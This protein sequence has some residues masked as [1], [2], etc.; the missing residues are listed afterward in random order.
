M[1]ENRGYS[2]GNNFGAKYLEQKGVEFLFIAN[3]DIEIS[4]SDFDVLLE[5]LKTGEYS[6]VSGVEYDALGN[7]TG[8]VQR[9]D[10]YI[11]DIANCLSIGRRI[12][13]KKQTQDIDF[14]IDIN[15]TEM[16]HGCFFGIRMHDFISIGGLD[17]KVFLYAEERIMSKKFEQCGLKQGIVTKS[18][19]IHNHR[20]S[21]ETVTKKKTFPFKVMYD[22]NIYYL[23]NYEEISKSKIKVLKVFMKIALFRMNVM[24]KIK[25]GSRVAKQI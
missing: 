11:D 23:E 5:V 15:E 16:L 3:P 24:G 22:S 1:D 21:I 4:E 9:R 13:N 7:I 8:K 25:V 12:I 14:S 18:R 20:P 2:Y 10:R 17:D 6:A 19:Y